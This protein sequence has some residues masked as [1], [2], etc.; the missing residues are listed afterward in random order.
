M[1]IHYILGCGG[2]RRV[3]EIILL[4][5]LTKILQQLEPEE[6][7][8]PHDITAKFRRRLLDESKTDVS[9]ELQGCL[10][11]FSELKK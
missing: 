3:T 5:D 7:S 8:L 1:A 9:V 6:F 11:F 4:T 2:P 10:Q